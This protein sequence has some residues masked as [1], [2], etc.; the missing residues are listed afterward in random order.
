MGAG[1]QTAAAGIWYWTWVWVVPGS[2]YDVDP[3]SEIIVDDFWTLDPDDLTY[4]GL[5]NTDFV[6]DKTAANSDDL[7][8]LY[9]GTDPLTVGEHLGTI[10]LVDPDVTPL[11]V[12]TVTLDYTLSFNT[13]SGFVQSSGTISSAVLERASW[14]LVIVGFGGLGAFGYSRR[15]RVGDT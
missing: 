14:A 15:T 10:T 4:G 7:I 3:P 1:V 6:I 2:G 8:L 13:T 12:Q 9:T 11:D 5:L